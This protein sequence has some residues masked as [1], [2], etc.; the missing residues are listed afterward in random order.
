MQW[1]IFLPTYSVL[2]Q[3]ELMRI[4]STCFRTLA[5]RILPQASSL[6]GPQ[7]PKQ[8]PGASAGCSETLLSTEAAGPPLKGDP[9]PAR[10]SD[11]VIG[12]P[13]LSLVPS[14]RN[15]PKYG[16]RVNPELCDKSLAEATPAQLAPG[17]RHPGEPLPLGEKED[18]APLSLQ[19]VEKNKL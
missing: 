13:C 16:P 14:P 3:P 4:V 7:D 19:P 10:V 6:L 2:K 1:L 17:Q 12:F 5:N 9:S 15:Y 18:T 8:A 11:L